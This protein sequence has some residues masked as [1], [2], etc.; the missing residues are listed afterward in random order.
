MCVFLAL[1]IF[2]LASHPDLF[3]ILSGSSGSIAIFEIERSG[4]GSA[5]HTLYG[6]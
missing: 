5:A 6:M 3:H 2:G 4:G 1:T